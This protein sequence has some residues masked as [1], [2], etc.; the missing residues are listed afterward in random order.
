[1]EI[2]FLLTKSNHYNQSLLFLQI[3]FEL[4]WEWYYKMFLQPLAYGDYF[5]KYNFVVVRRSIYCIDTILIQHIDIILKK[6]Y[7]FCKSL[8]VLFYFANIYDQGIR[9]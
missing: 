4:W 2:V 6:I 3:D 8:M 1:M 5:Y 7:W 9:H